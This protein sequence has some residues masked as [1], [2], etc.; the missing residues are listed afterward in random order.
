MTRKL[1]AE[2]F[3]A[4]VNP[5]GP[6]PLIRGVIGPCHLW[7]GSTNAAGYGTFWAGQSVK[8]HRFAYEQ[9]R[10]PIP[11]GLEL[12]HRCRQR[13]CVRV[14]HLDAVTHRV[15]I[16]RSSN[17]VAHRAAVTQCPA[18]HPYDAAN[19]YRAPNGTRKCRACNATRTRNT[20]AIK[21]EAQLAAVTPLH[22]RTD[23]TLE[24][25]A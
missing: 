13:A 10:G 4:K 20:R 15:N 25:A 3:A 2:R 1:P 16:L 14:S 12:D 18:G 6:L 24:R 21:R 9:A 7:E 23:P 19:T 17:H 22:P 11:T 5:A 8:A